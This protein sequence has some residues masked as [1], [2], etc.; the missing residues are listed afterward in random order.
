MDNLP[1]SHHQF[2]DDT[3]LMGQPSVREEKGI[4]QFLLDFMDAL[5]TYVSQEK[6]QL[7]FAPTIQA[8]ISRILD[9]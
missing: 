2:V 3:M 5:G 7:F 1:I 4:K 9:F 6:S 8:H